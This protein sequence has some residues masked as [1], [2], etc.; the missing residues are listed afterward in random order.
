MLQMDDR[1][2]DV[3]SVIVY[4][5]SVDALWNPRSYN[6]APQATADNLLSARYTV[7]TS[8]IREAKWI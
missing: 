1:P 2:L 6:A 3:L 5:I 4:L 7:Y 8:R